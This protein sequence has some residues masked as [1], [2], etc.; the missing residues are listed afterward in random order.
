MTNTVSKPKG[1][2]IRIETTTL[3]DVYARAMRQVGHDVFFLTGTDEHGI[4]VEQSANDK[5]VT[6]QE[7]ADEIASH[8]KQEHVD[9]Q[10]GN[11]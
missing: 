5:G 4:K 11:L 1:L 2:K 3:C 10:E 7:L 8:H 6:P 9:T